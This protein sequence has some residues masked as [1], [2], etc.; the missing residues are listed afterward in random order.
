MEDSS[1]QPWTVR[2]AAGSTITWSKKGATNHTV[3][4]APLTAEGTDWSFTPGTLEPGQTETRT[5][6]EAGAF[7][8]YCMVHGKAT[9]CSVVIVD[10]DTRSAQLPCASDGDIGGGY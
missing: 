7:E 6:D 1:C 8:Y 5:F 3:N 2:T 9:M 10:D 4:A